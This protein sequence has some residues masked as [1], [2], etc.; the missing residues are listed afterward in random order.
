MRIPA[1]RKW[2]CWIMV[3]AFAGL[4]VLSGCGGGGSKPLVMGS[5][6]GKVTLDGKALPAGCKITF[7]HKEKSFPATGD[8]GSDGSYT[9]LFN[10]K[11]A[12][13]VGT[14]DVTIVPPHEE[15][16]P[17]ADPSNP[18]A[19]KKMMMGG[20]LAKAPLNQ[21]AVPR[22][23]QVA[24]SSKLTCTVIEGQETVFDLDMKSGG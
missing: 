15:A 24:S 23:Y 5:V 1:I 8:I 14:Y 7:I 13:P 9:L 11:P 20:A 3:V 4:S 21:E 10:G 22:K 17:A 6:K 2:P 18:E 19:Y 12:V 16:G